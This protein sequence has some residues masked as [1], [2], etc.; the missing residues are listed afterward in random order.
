MFSSPAT[1]SR[2]FASG[3]TPFRPVALDPAWLTSTVVALAQGIYDGGAFDR[4]PI[5]AD[6]LQDA[7]CDSKDVLGH[8]RGPGPHA[9]GCWVVDLL[10]NKE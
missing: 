10:L 9:R 6:A 4:L 1:Y 8:C 2:P 3:F 5:L 7:G